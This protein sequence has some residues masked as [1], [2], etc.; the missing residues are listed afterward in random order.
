VGKRLALVGVGSWGGNYLRTIVESRQDELGLIVS[1]KSKLELDAVAATAARIL[2][3]IESLAAHAD[4]IDGAIVATPPQVRP[5]IVE[6]LLK[7]GIPVL[8]EK[9]LSLDPQTSTGLIRLAKSSG[10]YLMEDFIHI[11]SWPYLLLGTKLRESRPITIESRAGNQGPFRDYSPLFDYAPHDLAMV[12]QIFGRQPAK[13]EILPREFQSRL[14]FNAQVKLDFAEL[15]HANMTIGNLDYAKT[16]QFELTQQ[17]DLWIY[18]DN[19]GD[20]LTLNGLPQSSELAEYSSMQLLLDQFCGR[21]KFYETDRILWL[22][23]SVAEILGRLE[24]EFG[25]ATGQKGLQ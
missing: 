17:N 4:E 2:P 10:V 22:S 12:L 1:S 7:L 14:V 3:D 16:R 25:A 13:I 18:D 19:S 8:A 6:Q 5:A 21:R 11:Y 20:K 15:G 23:Q 9:P 24:T